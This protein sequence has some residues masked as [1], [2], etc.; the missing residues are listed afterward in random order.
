MKPFQRRDMIERLI[1][2]R[3][4]SGVDVLNAEFVAA[5]AKSS[6]AKLSIMAYGAHSCPQL[7][8]DLSDMHKAGRLTRKRVGVPESDG[9][10]L[11]RWKFIYQIK[12][13]TND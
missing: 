5:Y 9:A 13:T 6:G 4:K 7:G 3:F 12:E 10:G 2:E 1:R 11:P 8:A